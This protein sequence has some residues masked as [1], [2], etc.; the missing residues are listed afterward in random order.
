MTPTRVL[1]FVLNDS[2]DLVVLGR[3]GGINIIQ[4]S[5]ALSVLIAKGEQQRKGGDRT[6]R[7]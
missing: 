7:I 1:W 2:Y 3:Q 4:K 5:V 6:R